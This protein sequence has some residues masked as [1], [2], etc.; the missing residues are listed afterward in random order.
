MSTFSAAR[1]SYLQ[2]QVLAASPAR[3]V[4]MLYDRLL[5]DLGRAEAANVAGDWN[6]A[7]GHVV[8]AQRILTELMTTLD[9]DAWD[10]AVQ[11]HAIYSF[12]LSRLL[13][14]TTTRDAALV[15]TVRELLEPIREAWH[16]AAAM[17]PAL[18]SAAPNGSLGVA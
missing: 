5:L 13:T 10:G 4:T 18:R 9:V 16:E 1:Q 6:E 7:R 2:D 15:T 17:V 8:H 12:A 11:L 14:A 3:L